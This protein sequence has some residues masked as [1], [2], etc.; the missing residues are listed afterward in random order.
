MRLRGSWVI[1]AL[2]LWP[3][4]ALAE[5][6]FSGQ[7][8]E[9]YESSFRPGFGLLKPGRDDY[10]LSRGYLFAE[11]SAGDHVTLASEWVSGGVSGARGSLPATQE[12][13]LDILQLYAEGVFGSAGGQLRFRGGRQPLTLGAARLVSTRDN[14][15]VRRAFDGLRVTWTRGRSQV[16]GFHLEP[17]SP[18][19]GEFDDRPDPGH[20]FW[21]L[22][23]TLDRASPRHSGFDVYYLGLRASGSRGNERRHTV[24]ARSFGVAGSRDWNV[25]AAGQWGEL[26]DSR[27]R[28]WTL[29]WDAGYTFSSLQF[30]PRVGL[31]ADLISGDNDPGDGKWGTFNPL[32]PKLSYF[33][34]ANVTTPANLIDVQPTWSLSL[35]KGLRLSGSWNVLWR[36]SREDA[37]YLPPMKPVTIDESAGRYLGQQWSTAIEWQP[38]SHLTFAASGV[39]FRPG[40]A[41]LKAGG[42]SGHFVFVSAQAEF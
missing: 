17:V 23:W 8:R 30:S 9:R 15:N 27:I 3:A 1:S 13:P 16:D 39:A 26:G 37:F 33:S 28:A 12:D 2:L 19:D 7:V 36:Y 10:L 42:A 41:L 34:D 18:H 14:T 4:P 24:G 38:L 29:S 32:F 5:V 21:G 35:A 6:S 22:Y 31:K 11:A 25:E 20:R 40:S